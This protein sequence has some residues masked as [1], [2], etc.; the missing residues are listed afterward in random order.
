MEF[1][2]S[3]QHGII[4]LE[5]L[6]KSKTRVEHDTLPLNSRHHRGIG[7]IAQFTFHQR[8]NIW[9]RW[10]VPPFLWLAAH[11][12]QNRATFQG[13][14]RL[15]HLPVPSESTHVVDNLR[16]RLDR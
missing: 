13:S 7:P 15:G 14:Q 12:H 8:N 2:E 4:S 5:A 6:A 1:F 11:V 10:K 16:S 3:L 9:N